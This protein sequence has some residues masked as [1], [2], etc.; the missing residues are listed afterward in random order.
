MGKMVLELAEKLIHEV[1]QKDLKVAIMDPHLFMLVLN[2]EL[3]MKDSKAKLMET[4]LFKLVLMKHPYLMLF[5]L[6][7]M[8][9]DSKFATMLSF[10]VHFI[11]FKESTFKGRH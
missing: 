1:K 8:L 10:V 5:E 7:G 11:Q 6:N 2:F 3:G 4:Y 9:M